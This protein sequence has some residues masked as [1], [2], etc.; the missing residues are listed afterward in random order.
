MRRLIQIAVII[1]LVSG[2]AG[3]VGA[4]ELFDLPV[5]VKVSFDPK[6]E[7]IADLDG[8]GDMDL[9]VANSS[10]SVIT[11]LLNDGEGGFDHLHAVERP[12]GHREAEPRP[13]VPGSLDHTNVAPEHLRKTPADD[14][15]QPCAGKPARRGGVGLCE[16][17]EQPGELL[18][19]HATQADTRQS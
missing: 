9:A 3:A 5:N 12:G 4:E 14:Q 8:D 7:C 18:W 6:D 10:S 13:E 17:L 19:R 15:A 16:R 2:A 1:A 11:V